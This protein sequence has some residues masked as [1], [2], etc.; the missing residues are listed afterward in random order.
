M[1]I[2]SPEQLEGSVRAGSGAGLPHTVYVLDESHNFCRSWIGCVSGQA[3]CSDSAAQLSRVP[4]L[5]KQLVVENL[6]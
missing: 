4:A 5:R 1:G 3:G 2:S 6:F